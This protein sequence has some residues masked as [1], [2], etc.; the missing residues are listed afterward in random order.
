MPMAVMA[1]L[2][3]H[4]VAGMRADELFVNDFADH[5]GSI[6]PS[7][8]YWRSLRIPFQAI[9]VF[10]GEQFVFLEFVFLGGML[11]FFDGQFLLLW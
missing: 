7:R 2:V 6:A 3:W 10:V 8:R 5:I 1:E 11:C 9:Y 4:A